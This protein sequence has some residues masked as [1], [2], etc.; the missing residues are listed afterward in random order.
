MKYTKD[1]QR[2]WLILQCRYYDGEAEAPKHFMHEDSM[3]WY[4][5]KCWV[6]F[7]FNKE[8]YDSL[9]KDA[10]CSM[11][12]ENPDD[13]TPF[14]LKF[15]LFN[16][17]EH[18]GGGYCPIE[19][20]ID[21]FE[22]GYYARYLKRKTNKQR[23]TEARSAE[24]V[25]KCRYY[26]GEE[27][28]PYSLEHLTSYWTWEKEWVEKIADSYYNRQVFVAQMDKI[29]DVG[30]ECVPMLDL[31]SKRYRMPRTMIAYFAMKWYEG[32]HGGFIHEYSTY[33]ES[34]LEEYSNKIS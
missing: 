31:M 3:F 29:P 14:T 28:S 25:K 32:A 20:E 12:R 21:N 13:A 24:L 1:Q 9:K 30:V 4:Y 18:W 17:Y 2:H 34:F 11:L 27:K 23:R 10:E 16:R 5:E 33:F 22:S 7:H 19:K 26:H 15:I 6:E 8:N